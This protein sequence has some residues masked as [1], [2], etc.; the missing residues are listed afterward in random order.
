[1][2]DP[3]VKQLKFLIALE[4]T[5]HFRRAADQVGV[6]QPSLSAQIQVLEE[7]LGLRLVE[8][9]RGGVRMTPAGREVCA[10]ARGVI[11][12]VR[13][14]VEFAATA[15]DGLAGTIRLGAKATLGP[16]L[17]PHVVGALHAAHP[18]L[19]LYIREEAPRVLEADLARGTH[20]AILTQLPVVGDDYATARLFRE[21][22][23]LAL[24][25]DHKLTRADRITPDD[26][27][28]ESMLTL[29]PA[30]HLHDQITDVCRDTGAKLAR[31]YEGTSL[32]A[33]RQMVGMGM[34][35]TLL[36]ALYVRSEI[37]G[38]GAEV[39]VRTIAGRKLSRTAGLVWRRQSARARGFREIAEVIRSVARKSWPELLIES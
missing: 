21:P 35:L 38:R 25:A 5:A 10:R 4:E 6:T 8:R 9:G 17:L 11:D 16:Y 19:R 30:Y 18:D 36:P 13:D 22:L 29:S 14:L 2:P 7:R 26:L 3:T 23:M 15:R 33:L 34:G 1:M 31:D 27:R 39:V 20:D 12:G 37:E 32:D 28:G 24:P